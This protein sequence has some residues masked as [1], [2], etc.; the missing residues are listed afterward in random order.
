VASAKIVPSFD[1]I[2]RIQFKSYRRAVVGSPDRRERG[3]LLGRAHSRRRMS[4]C[5]AASIDIERFRW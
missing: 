2:R 5:H 3:V 4:A 1:R